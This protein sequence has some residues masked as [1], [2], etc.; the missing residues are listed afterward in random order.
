MAQLYRV[1]ELTSALLSSAVSFAEMYGLRAYDAVQLAAAVEL[2]AQRIRTGLSHVTLVSAD[3]ELNNAAT[4]FGMQ[5][6]N[7]NDYP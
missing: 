3:D 1:I 7:P 4:A 5:V 6:E 2:N